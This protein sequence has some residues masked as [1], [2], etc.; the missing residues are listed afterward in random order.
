MSSLPFIPSSER[1][2]VVVGPSGAGKDSVLAAWRHRLGALPVHFAQRVVSRPTE[3]SEQHEPISA[4]DFTRAVADGEFAT[5]WH[6]HGLGYGLRWRE[7][8][9]IAEGR[10][11][12]LNGSREHLPALRRQAPALRAVEL[13]APPELLA[14]RLQARAREDR[15]SIARRLHRQPIVEADH[16]ISNNTHLAA[17][18]DALHCWWSSLDTAQN[19]VGALDQI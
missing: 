13:T 7:L 4:C 12:V 10:W 6:A 8:A 17:A 11:V 9:P 5:S 1:L 15:Q 3:A 18:V 2:L 19:L 14:Q 16:C